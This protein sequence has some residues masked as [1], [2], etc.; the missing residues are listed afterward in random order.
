MIEDK[1]G[2]LQPH[3]DT[4]TCIKCHKC[5]KTCP[6]I[7]PI[8]IPTDFE[9]QAF[10]AINKDETVRLRSSSGGM[11]HALAKWTIM[12]GGVVFGARFNE[13]WEV[14]HDYTETLEGIEPF[15]RSKY[16]QSSI[17]ETFKQ[18]KQFL[19]QGRQVLFVGTPCQIVG[20][21]SFLS[22]DYPNLISVDFICHGVP[23]SGIWHKYLCQQFPSIRLINTINF[24]D[25]ANGWSSLYL[26]RYTTSEENGKTIIR[27]SNDDPYTY[28]FLNDYYLRLC[29]YK[30]Q[31]K[32][33]NRLSDITI[34]DAWSIENYMP[35]MADGKGTS[36]C[37]IHTPR[38]I[39]VFKE[40][41][42]ALKTGA[43]K[44]EIPLQNNR[45]AT[46]SVKLT[47]A[48]MLFYLFNNFT[49]VS[50]SVKIVQRMS[51]IITKS[52]RVI[53]RIF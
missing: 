12:Q 33:I 43:L 29:C 9:T 16:V 45:R 6:I 39:R 17:G 4:D 15:M 11:F 26:V 35:D 27:N 53:K 31:F 18:T 51:K 1:E 36:L 46:T 8:T 22:K 21:K 42:T 49:T 38:G 50:K 48:R 2:F 23:A 3:I 10:A 20:L 7:S 14:V 5:E 44:I 47:K 30:C 52:K 32:T 19:N 25:K 34:A 37:L 41:Q 28:G 24:R 13:N 40:V